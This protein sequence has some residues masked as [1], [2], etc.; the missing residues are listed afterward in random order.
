MTVYPDAKFQYQGAN[1]TLSGLRLGPLVLCP[2]RAYG[3]NYW[4]DPSVSIPDITLRPVEATVKEADPCTSEF[5]I[6]YT[7]YQADPDKGVPWDMIFRLTSDQAGGV[8]GT[9][10][11]LLVDSNYPEIDMAIPRFEFTQKGFGIMKMANLPGDY[12]ATLTVK[13][14]DRGATVA[15][16]GWMMLECGYYKD[17]AAKAR[18]AKGSP[19]FTALVAIGRSSLYPACPGDPMAPVMGNSYRRKSP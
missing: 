8:I 13:F 4:T 16:D 19:D 10:A 14:W 1:L 17:G 15:L 12:Q 5:T 9:E 7:Q 11:Q 3:V 2:P 18:A 6:F